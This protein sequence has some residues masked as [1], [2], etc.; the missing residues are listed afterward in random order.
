MNNKII[1]PLVLAVIAVGVAGIYW[2]ILTQ[3]ATPSNLQNIILSPLVKG[4]AE[5]GEEI[6]SKSLVEEQ[7]P[8]ID[9]N[10]NEVLYLRAI[11]HLCC[12]KV[13]I[14]KEI[15]N[16]VINIYE[17]WSG[18]G[19]RCICFSEIGAK[20]QNVPPGSYTI[21][22]YEKGTKPEIKEPMEQK[23][24]ISKDIIVQ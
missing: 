17:V 8:K 16:S 9:V 22:V 21:N 15:R 4:C 3:S 24:I 10:G 2:Q 19:C 5:T 11:N 20:L 7:E 1:L 12:R 6:A 18:I 23:L 14:E 13:E